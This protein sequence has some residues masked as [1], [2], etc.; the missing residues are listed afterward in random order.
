MR[1]C[2]ILPYINEPSVEN[3]ERITQVNILNFVNIKE[4]IAKCQRLHL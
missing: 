3:I 1:Y 4:E 2:Q